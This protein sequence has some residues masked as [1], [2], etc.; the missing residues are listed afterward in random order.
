MDKL[1]RKTARNYRTIFSKSHIVEV[2]RQIF[3]VITKSFC[4]V[5]EKSFRY[6]D[7]ARKFPL[8]YN[9]TVTE[10]EPFLL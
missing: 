1:G 6:R 4:I 10:E 7:G 2:E 9:L 3:D 8:I 5:I